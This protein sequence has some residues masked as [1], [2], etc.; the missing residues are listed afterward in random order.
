MLT[1]FFITLLFTFA[2]EE[3]PEPYVQTGQASYYAR[4]LEGRETADGSIYRKDSMTAAHRTL[5]MGTIIKVTNLENAQ[6]VTVEVNDRGPF[7]KSRILDLSRSAAKKLEM[8]EDGAV[9]VRLEIVEP[10]P[11]YSISDSVEVN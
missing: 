2:C 10:A 7:A 5:P 1:L 3:K 6:E 9:E 8:M 11:G 4:M